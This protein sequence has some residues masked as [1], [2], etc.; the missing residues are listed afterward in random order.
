MDPEN[1]AFSGS[2]SNLSVFPTNAATELALLFR[3]FL[4]ANMNNNLTHY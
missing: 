4:T 2:I 1:E 3:F